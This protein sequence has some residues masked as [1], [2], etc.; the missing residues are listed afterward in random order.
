MIIPKRRL[1]FYFIVLSSSLW[2]YFATYYVFTS[3]DKKKFDFIQDSDEQ[4]VFATYDKS[5]DRN[6]EK[7]GE[8]GAAVSL[9]FIEKRLEDQGYKEHAFNRVASDKVSLER[10]LL[11]VRNKKY[12]STFAV[13][14][15]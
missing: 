8:W 6:P 3:S 2:I 9:N 14:M 12:V 10:N 5:P 11:D 4:Y 15:L 7:P 13:L 1:V